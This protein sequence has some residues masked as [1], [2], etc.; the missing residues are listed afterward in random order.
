MRIFPFPFFVAALALSTPLSASAAGVYVSKISTAGS[1]THEWV[2]VTNVG[3][4]QADLTAWK[5]W[6]SQTNHGIKASQGAAI[7]LPGLRA[8]VAEDATTFLA[9]HPSSTLQVFDSS[10]GSLSDGGEEIGLRDASGTPIETFVYPDTGGGAIARDSAD[11]ADW[12]HVTGDAA[13]VETSCAPS[14]VD[15]DGA[16]TGADGVLPDGSS[17]TPSDIATDPG[18][19]ADSG[20]VPDSAATTTTPFLTLSEVYPA[21]PSGSKEWV[22]VWNPGSSEVPAGSCEIHDSV[23]K[24]AVQDDAV[25]AE[26]YLAIEIPTSKL[27]NDG[28]TASVVCG[29]IVDD[30]TSYGGDTTPG[31][32]ESLARESLPDGAWKLTTVLTPGAPNSIVEPP[33]ASGGASASQPT[34]RK[35]DPGRVL[36]NEIFPG[37]TDRAWIELANPEPKAISL[38]GWSLAVGADSP[39]AL[40]GTL[41]AYGHRVVRPLHGPISASAGI[42]FLIDPQGYTIDEVVW[43][44]GD[45]TPA[46]NAPAVGADGHSLA[47]RF[48]ALASSGWEADFMD[49]PTP[50]PGETNGCLVTA[51]ADATLSIT[52]VLPDPEGPDADGEFVEIAN[53]GQ[54]TVNLRGWKLSVGDASPRPLPAADLAPGA[55][56]ALGRDDA[57][58]P[59]P[60]SGGKI[61]LLRPDG[62]VADS[63]SYGKLKTGVA[64][65]VDGS[66]DWTE[67][68]SP[69][70]GAANAIVEPNDPPKAAFATETPEGADRAYRF[71]G[72]DSYDP[73]G[74]L[75][76]LVWDFGDGS[77]T[78]EA[79]STGHAF[80][81]AG[82]YPVSLTVYDSSGASSTMS[83]IVNV[84]AKYSAAADVTTTTSSPP[85]SVAKKATAAKKVTSTK[86]KPTPIETS[87]T[88][89]SPA[90]ALGSR[91]VAIATADGNLLLELP[92][93]SD[94]VATGDTVTAE[95]SAGTRSGKAILKV[96]EFSV[97]DGAGPT[98]VPLEN[99]DDVENLPEY[100]LVTARGTVVE[101]TTTSLLLSGTGELKVLL[102]RTGKRGSYAIGEVVEATG[103][104]KAEAD[105]STDLATRTV[106]DLRILEEAPITTSTPKA[107]IPISPLGAGAAGTASG[108]LA[109]AGWGAT[110]G[111]RR[112][113]L[114]SISAI[115][116]DRAS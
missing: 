115:R 9:D 93:T 60:N 41:P 96:T 19:D 29:G 107:D 32:G 10:W 86:S 87:G 109:T 49:C 102:P 11:S 43:G 26:G 94:K 36:V 4:E 116:P 89:L 28:D 3:S 88:A 70:P 16:A 63:M 98:P 95:G 81:Q 77:A 110:A 99:L 104:V 54:A 12:C 83:R 31:S 62:T 37:P 97:A 8:I 103:L 100:S 73:D 58:R 105:G 106:A 59:L 27:N 112:R 24:I 25:L 17:G 30:S 1:A 74:D 45:N 91:L 2:E 38:A 90:G 46:D 57:G 61:G 55:F 113:L 64:L 18:S 40:E 66:G 92:K 5:F 76:A 65:A 56:L 35:H 82:K 79:T 69:T 22:E 48:D 42:A 71:D 50:S 108:V 21:P 114:D 68:I 51:D 20:T 78:V 80:A 15:G 84:P 7:L 52:E 44:N 67:T 47:R 101:K 53:L 6:E 75:A 23:G 85:K 13:G 39:I 111:L 33:V 14:S 34:S 72:S